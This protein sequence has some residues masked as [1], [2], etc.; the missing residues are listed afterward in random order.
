MA[1][2]K[3]F[4]KVLSNQYSIKTG[5]NKHLKEEVMTFW[6]SVEKLS[7]GEN[8]NKK[9]LLNSNFISDQL[10]SNYDDLPCYFENDLHAASYFSGLVKEA[11]KKEATN[12]ELFKLERRIV[13][14]EAV[15]KVLKNSRKIIG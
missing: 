8:V 2:V 5:C 14:L 10:W 11:M 4:V 7:I 13:A 12:I 9:E 1:E 6:D 15:F 3:E